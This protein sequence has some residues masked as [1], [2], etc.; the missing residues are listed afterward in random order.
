MK[1]AYHKKKARDYYKQ[2][3]MYPA[4]C[5]H[6]MLRILRPDLYAGFKKHYQALR[7]IDPTTPPMPD[8]AK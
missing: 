6:H 3:M 4:G 8:W 1:K 5:G 2:I 7:E